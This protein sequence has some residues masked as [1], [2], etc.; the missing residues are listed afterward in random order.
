VN[1]VPVGLLSIG[2]DMLKCGAAG[3]KI[4]F[5]GGWTSG[6]HSSRVDI[7]DTTTKT[8]SIAELTDPYRDGM[9]VATVGDKVLFAGGGD[10]DWI[11]VTSR[12]DIYN[13]T[14][15]SWSTAEL[16]VARNDL[17]A[18]TLGKKVF[19]AGGA[20][21]GN[22]RQG[23]NVID[24]YDNDTNTWTTAHLSEGRYELTATAV[25]N[26]IYFAGGINNMYSISRKIDV[27]DSETNSWS[28]SQLYEPKTGHA[29]IAVDKKIFWAGGATA[30]YQRGYPAS[31]LVEIKDVV[32]GVSTL[33]CITP[34]ARFDV[35]RKNNTLVFFIGHN[36][37]TQIDI[38]DTTSN[39]WSIGTLPFSMK[40]SA[41]ICVNNTIYVAG[42]YSVWKL[43][44]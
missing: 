8:W 1:L 18:V 9:A 3:S 5:A 4:L 17:A 29:A 28:V 25:G 20:T 34:K 12:V 43:E 37:N 22:I 11:D 42:G 7:F 39:T 23:S 2:R 36:Q 24:I 33:D 14:T 32:A 10:Y 31:S 16:S 13:A 6:G 30:S 15:N 40:A 35:V 19:F 44:F 41:I 38:F 21:W 27:F 26:K